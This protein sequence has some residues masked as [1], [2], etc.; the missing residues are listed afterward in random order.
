M[1]KLAD[2]IWKNAELLRGAYKENEYRKVILPFTILRRLDCVLQPTRE[3]VRARYAAV[4]SKGY[5]LD[6]MLTPV[7]GYPFFNTSSFTLPNIAETPDDV[8]DNLEAMINGFS[9]NVRD[10]FDKFEFAATLDKLAEKNRLYL[11]VQRFAE[12]DLDP[13]TVTNHDMGQAFEELLRKFNDVSPAG[14]Q[15]TPRDVIELMVTLLFSGDDEAL[16]VPGVIRTMYDPTAGTG[17]ILS[18]AEEHLRKFNDRATLKLFGQEL[19]DETYAICKADMLIRG[20][21]PAD[22]KSGDTLANDLHPDKTFEYQAAN[23]PY[24]VEWKP[25]EAAVKK[26]HAKGAA[27]RFGPGLPAIRD[28]QMLFSL[29]LLSKMQPVVAGKGGGRIGVV[30]NGSPLFT[31]DAGSGESEIRRH[32]LEHDYLDCIVALPTDMFYNTNITTYLWFMTNRKPADRKGKVLLIDATAMS[33]LMK[34]NLGKK[35]REF[36]ADCVERITKAY[37]DFKAMEWSEDPEGKSGRV[38]KA[39]VFDHEHFF[40][41]RV[42]IERPLRMRFQI[43]L[44]RWVDLGYDTAAAK[45]TQDQSILLSEAVNRMDNDVIYRDA[46]SFRS[47]LHAAAEAAANELELTGKAAKLTAKTVELARKYFG[48][49]DKDAEPTTNEKGEVLSDSELRDAEYVPFNDDIE[50][51]FDKEVR[52]HWPDAWINYDVKDSA[53]GKTG[54]VGTEINFNR[55]FYVYTPPRSREAIAADIE[56]KEHKFMELLRGI[57]GEVC[58]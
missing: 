40:Y 36:T 52:P 49:K 32:I 19:E 29:H 30:H 37:A 38:L 21:N 43:E 4:R 51:Y 42:T 27:G 39:K 10:I 55:E 22:I 53:D 31:G 35:R 44:Q 16:S 7:S 34:K 13:A 47:A 24:G 3:A 12:T 46:E 54:M 26:E 57:K 41:R 6:K 15:Y 18:V 50:A 14:E 58:P 33:V 23:P 9:Q 45:L 5:D 28:G 11:V 48:T 8:R 25:A 1:S 56:A 17:G 2:L 20:Q